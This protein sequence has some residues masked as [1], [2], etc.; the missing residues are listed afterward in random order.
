MKV[1]MNFQLRFLMSMTGKMQTIDLTKLSLM[2]L[3]EFK[4]QVNQSLVSTFL[5]WFAWS[6]DNTYIGFE[7]NPTYSL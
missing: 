5:K 7:I 2:Q 1:K 6:H 4:N 3:T